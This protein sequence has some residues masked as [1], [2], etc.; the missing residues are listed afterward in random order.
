MKITA[1]KVGCFSPC[2]FLQGY[3]MLANVSPGIYIDY[4]CMQDPEIQNPAKAVAIL[5]SKILGLFVAKKTLW[6]TKSFS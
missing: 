2:S 1:K 3:N 5:R 6:G 4:I